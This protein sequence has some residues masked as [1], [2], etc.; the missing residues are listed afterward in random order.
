MGGMRLGDYLPM[1]TFELTVL[2]PRIIG[3]LPS[4]MAWLSWPSESTR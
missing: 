4:S 3:V 1:R 2:Q